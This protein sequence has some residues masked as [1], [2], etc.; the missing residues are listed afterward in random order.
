[1]GAS[2]SQMDARDG[3][4][5]LASGTAQQNLHYGMRIPN[6]PY[7]FASFDTAL[8][9]PDLLWRGTRLTLSYDGYYQH[10]FPL[11][12]EGFGSAESRRTVPTQFSHNLSLTY[13]LAQGRYNLTLEC[14]NLTDAKLYDN[15]SLQKPGRAFYGKIR[16]CFGK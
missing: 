7:R 4:R 13:S 2:F 10:A 5:Y 14:Q 12:W 8:S 15:Y 1:M 9:W 6:Q 16:I 3:V 11:T